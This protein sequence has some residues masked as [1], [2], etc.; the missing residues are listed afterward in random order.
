MTG[1]GRNYFVTVVDFIMNIK[2]PFVRISYCMSLDTGRGSVGTTS[3]LYSS[4]ISHKFLS[5]LVSGFNYRMQKGNRVTI[6]QFLFLGGV[7]L[8]YKFSRVPTVISQSVGLTIEYSNSFM[9]E[10]GSS[11]ICLYWDHRRNWRLEMFPNLSCRSSF[12]D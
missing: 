8:K 6:N 2:K 10:A 4:P 5:F 1:K 11:Q 12:H 3:S 7:F 9:Q